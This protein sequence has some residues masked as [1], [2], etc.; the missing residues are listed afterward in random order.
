MAIAN[1]AAGA[2]LHHA[3]GL[4]SGTHTTGVLDACILGVII[5][6]LALPTD[7]LE[8]IGLAETDTIGTQLFDSATNPA[9]G[10]PMAL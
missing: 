1:A 8:Q 7:T 6:Q 3:A 2:D 4:P 9:A 10:Y 5:T